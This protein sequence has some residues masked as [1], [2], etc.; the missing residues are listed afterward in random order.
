MKNQKIA[1]FQVCFSDRCLS[2]FKGKSKA[3]R[4]SHG[5]LEQRHLKSKGRPRQADQKKLFS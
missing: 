2:S 3:R 5:K 1:A 4:Q